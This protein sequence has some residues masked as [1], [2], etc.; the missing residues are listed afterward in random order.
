MMPFKVAIPLGVT[1]LV[2]LTTDTTVAYVS[3]QRGTR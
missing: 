1:T 3:K 2:L